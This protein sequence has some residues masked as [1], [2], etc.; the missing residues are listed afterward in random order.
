MQE[1]RLPGRSAD[2]AGALP[3]A[4]R[5]FVAAFAKKWCDS[6]GLWRALGP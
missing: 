5:W 4:N 2:E 3:A 6:H 1:L